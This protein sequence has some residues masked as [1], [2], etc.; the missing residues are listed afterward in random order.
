MLVSALVD[1]GTLTVVETLPRGSV[2]AWGLGLGVPLALQGWSG[3]RARPSGSF[4]PSGVWRMWLALILLLGLGAAVS[5]L[6]LAPT[7]SL[8]PIHALTM[9]LL[10]LIV[11][12]LVG[13]ALGG[14]GGS[15]REVVAGLAGGGFLA[16]SGSL[17]GEALVALLVLL[18]VVAGVVLIAPGGAEQI[19]ALVRNLQDPAWMA[20]MDNLLQLL[21]SPP[22]AILGL[23]LFCVPVPLIEETFKT[24][25]AGVVARWVRPHPARAF[26]WGV[27]G[28]AG[29]ALGENLFNGALGG[30]GGWTLAAGARFGATMM[31]CFT[32]GL[33]GWGWGQLWTARR[34]KRMLASYAAAV[35]IH[36]LWNAITVGVV[37][38]SAS[39]A[40][41]EGDGSRLSLAGLGALALLG[42][43]GALAVTSAFALVLAGR[44]LAAERMRIPGGSAS[45][46]EVSA[47]LSSS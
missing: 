38:L 25:A 31:H 47:P 15:W 21:L 3:W 32:G 26:L 13:R 44:R 18:V 30:A 39:A 28:G 9:A 22:V 45:S 8:P 12:A 4:H 40:V 19:A 27:A 10:P 43:L 35:G 36:S 2:V 33:T 1:R 16:L 34:P 6:S 42:L 23:G 20:D 5:W 14:V 41:Y 11:L 7:W 17:I 46:T 37:L 29:F 24:L